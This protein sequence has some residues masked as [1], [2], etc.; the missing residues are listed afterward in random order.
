MDKP[1]H[2]PGPWV[3]EVYDDIEQAMDA[4]GFK[5]TFGEWDAERLGRPAAV[6]QLHGTGHTGLPGSIETTEANARLIA[7]APDLLAACR[8]LEDDPGITS[9]AN[10]VIKAALAKA[11]P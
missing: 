9:G 4:C 7:A 11:R 8:M 5:W 1:S 3:V 6:W 10:A 2:T